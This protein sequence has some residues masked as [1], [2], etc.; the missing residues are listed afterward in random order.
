MIGQQV[1]KM[2]G[3]RNERPPDFVEPGYFPCT[4]MFPATGKMGS[5]ASPIRFNSSRGFDFDYLVDF[6]NETATFKLPPL[7]LPEQKLKERQEKLYKFGRL[8]H[9]EL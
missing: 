9:I 8:V 3:I 4:I 7:K 1:G 6:V 5:Q 2:D